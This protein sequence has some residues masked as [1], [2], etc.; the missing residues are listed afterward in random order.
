MALVNVMLS[1]YDMSRAFPPTVNQHVPPEMHSA[2]RQMS[3]APQGGSPT[4]SVAA[5]Q[6]TPKAGYGEG[7]L[8]AN[9]VNVEQSGLSSRLARLMLAP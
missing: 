6:G 1:I 9:R 3:S 5:D 2:T 4:I 8:A 7:R